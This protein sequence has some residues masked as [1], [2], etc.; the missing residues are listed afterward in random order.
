[1]YYY[2]GFLGWLVMSMHMV[3]PV[4]LII[5]A[6]NFFYKRQGDNTSTSSKTP[7]DALKERYAKGEINKDEFYRIKDEITS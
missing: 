3:V 1:M 2:H 4:L 5:L 7:V 6:V